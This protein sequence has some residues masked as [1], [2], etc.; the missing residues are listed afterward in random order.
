MKFADL[1][2]EEALKRHPEEVAEIITKLRSGKSKSRNVAPEALVWSYQGSVRVEG[3]GTLAQVFAA[4]SKPRAVM[5]L[6]AKVA[7]QLRR[8][9]VGLHASVGRWYG[10]VELPVPPPEVEESARAGFVKEAAEQTRIAALTPAERQQEI[11]ELLGQL[12][13]S[14]GFME[15]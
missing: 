2:Y 8:T 14:S 1:S 3:S 9:S 15:F 12:R 13:K 11:A 5:S 6:D 10:Y 7:D 4:A